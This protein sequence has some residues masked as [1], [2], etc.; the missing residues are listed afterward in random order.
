[1][2]SSI[3]TCELLLRMLVT[4]GISFDAYNGAL[5]KEVCQFA[6]VTMNCNPVH[7]LILQLRLW[8]VLCGHYAGK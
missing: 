7:G 3:S 6:L 2:E 8:C 5:C 4:I 1:M